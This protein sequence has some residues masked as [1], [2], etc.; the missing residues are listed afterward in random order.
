MT[1]AGASA[2]PRDMRAFLIIWF[3]EMISL[4][5]S[6][7][8]NFGLGVWIFQKTGQATPFALSVL[9][10]SLPSV[11]LMPLA[12]M[13]ADRW[14]R[15]WLMLLADSGSALTTLVVVFLAG[16]GRLEVWH[17][18]LIVLCSSAFGAF[19]DPAY[20]SSLVLLVPRKDLPRANGLLS[21][22][23]ALSTLLA[24]L[25]AG[26]LFGVIGL[27]GIILID[28]V[29]YFAA[30]AALLIV[31]IPQPPL[32]PEE[33]GK[34]ASLVR[35]TAFAWGYLVARPGLLALVWYFALVNFLTNL[36]I[37]L[38]TP[39]VLGF[40]NVG[41]LGAMEMILGGGMLVGSIVISAWGG[42]KRR[43]AGVVG[44]ISLMA[45]GLSLT[46]L[47]PSALLIGAGLLLMTFALP[48]AR[49]SAAA[50]MQAKT[51]P[52]VQGR[53][54]AMRTL[55][56]QSTLPLAYLSAGPLADLI[57]N[58]LLRPGGGLSASLAGTVFGVGP[59]RGVGL[60]FSLCG[61][62]LLLV[63]L[64]A[65]TNPRIRNVEDELPD[66]V[67]EAAAEPTPADAA[68]PTP[69]DAAPSTEGA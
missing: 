2:G 49:A 68:E 52:S 16:S 59:G 41:V 31:R 35:D 26:L 1:T 61:L 27:S 69:A 57:F 60:L 3:G 45:L 15:R 9:C 19:Q 13:L 36:A 66:V 64:F 12:G 54:L 34:K 67:I 48:F 28:F 10:A 46:G 56:S 7:L 63:S 53:V 44:F 11:L 43:S 23:D 37:V 20:R 42:P 51:E 24:P 14:N 33:A 65:W 22:S 38:L 18:Y 62:V 8:T 5:G 40:S 6:G 21:A 58:P 25:L 55:I 50:I 29:T 4:I 30:L 32:R 47:R 39:L 17:V